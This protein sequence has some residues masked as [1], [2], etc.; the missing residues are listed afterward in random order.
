VKSD[1]PE[2]AS[3]KIVVAGGRALK[4]LENFKLIFDLADKLGAGGTRKLHTSIQTPF[5]CSRVWVL[6]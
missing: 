3:A 1:R 2:L 6:K 4:S 5:F